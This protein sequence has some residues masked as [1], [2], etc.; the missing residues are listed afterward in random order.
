MKK[1]DECYEIA[2][3]EVLSWIHDHFN[4]IRF[5]SKIRLSMLSQ[6]TFTFR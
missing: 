4:V 1:M 5:Q 2:L 6:T 3:Q